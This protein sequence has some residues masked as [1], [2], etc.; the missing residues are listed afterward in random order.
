LDAGF[1]IVMLQVPT[2]VEAYRPKCTYLY[3]YNILILLVISSYS[4]CEGI[5]EMGHMER[6]QII[7]SNLEDLLPVTISEIRLKFSGIACTFNICG[8]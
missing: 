3:I 5:A 4:I 1:I 8:V 6:P 7:V 2:N